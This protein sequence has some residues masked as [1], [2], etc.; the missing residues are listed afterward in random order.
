MAVEL[1][2]CQIGVLDVAGHY[3]QLFRDKGGGQTSAEIVVH[4][5]GG[6]GKTAALALHQTDAVPGDGFNVGGALG[7]FRMIIAGGVIIPGALDAVADAGEG[8]GM[9]QTVKMPHFMAQIIGM[10]GLARGGVEAVVTGEV[11][12]RMAVKKLYSGGGLAVGMVV[13][14]GHIIHPDHL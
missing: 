13:A 9:Q 3:V 8:K 4:D 6:S 10:A 14:F 2:R 11:P 5:I 1:S 12:Q 7:I